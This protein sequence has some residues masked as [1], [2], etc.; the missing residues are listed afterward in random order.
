M[1]TFQMTLIMA[2]SK[3]S[4]LNDQEPIRYDSRWRQVKKKLSPK[5]FQSKAKV[6]QWQDSMSY[7]GL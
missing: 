5:L 3:Y 1:R 2:T 4:S 6:R 7:I